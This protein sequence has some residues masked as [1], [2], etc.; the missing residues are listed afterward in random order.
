MRLVWLAPA[1]RQRP[2]LRLIISK[3][4]EQ[5]VT[6]VI[7]LT[8]YLLILTAT[9]KLTLLTLLLFTWHKREV[10]WSSRHQPPSTWPQSRLVVHP[11][12][13]FILR[14]E[15][16]K[17]LNW[18]RLVCS[19]CVGEICPNIESLINWCLSNL[20]RAEPQYCPRHSVWV[21][22]VLLFGNKRKGWG[23]V[24]RQTSKSNEE[25]DKQ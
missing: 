5:P 4:I 3:D 13:P 22:P 12:H 18:W 7:T 2:G 14:E 21:G 19:I 9:I 11:F 16:N 17:R 25:F 23:L 24:I 6:P 20:C 10:Y 1:V 8:R 15:R